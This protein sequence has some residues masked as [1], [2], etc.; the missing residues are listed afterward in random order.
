MKKFERFCNLIF[1]YLFTWDIIASSILDYL[2]S[3]RWLKYIFTNNPKF[4]DERYHRVSTYS[5]QSIILAQ[6][7]FGTLIAMILCIIINFFQFVT[8]LFFYTYIY[9]SVVYLFF[10]IFLLVG[11]SILFNYFFLFKDKKYLN[12]FDEFDK[13]EGSK[14]MGYGWMAFVLVIIII[15]LTFV[16]FW[17]TIS[18]S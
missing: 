3:F 10:L 8:G 7:G 18:Y 17:A 12:Y 11:V 5:H 1:Y 6:N 4:Y 14:K 9:N 13:M 16:S 2:M 15:L